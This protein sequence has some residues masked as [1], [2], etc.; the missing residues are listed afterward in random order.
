MKKIFL[1]ILFL[2]IVS[3]I[4]AAQTW[5]I[6]LDGGNKSQCSGLVDQPLSGA[7]GTDCRLSNPLFA[8]GTEGGDTGLM[9][10][11]DT[12]YIHSGAYKIG[13]GY[14]G[15]DGNCSNNAYSQDCKAR[16]IPS[17]PDVNHK[18][19][20]L[21]EGWD[22]EG[23]SRA[24]ELYGVEGAFHILSL[25]GS[26]NVE[27]QNLIITDHAQ[28]GRNHP[29]SA[30]FC[31]NS[32][33]YGN[34][35]Q[36]GIYAVDS[37]NVLLKNLIIRGLAGR[38]VMA[39]RIQ[40]WD[41][42]NVVISGNP[43]ID[44]EGDLGEP[45]A[46]ANKGTFNFS[47][48]QTR[49]AGCVDKYPLT[50]VR[51]VSES[52]L[53]PANDSCYGQDAGGGNGDGFSV[54]IG[55]PLDG[56][57]ATFNF[58]DS[59]FSDNMQDGLD[60]LH[61][62]VG[63]NFNLKRVKSVGNIGQQIKIAGNATA[64]DSII[65]GDC[66]HMAGQAFTLPSG[67]G[68]V[69]PCRAG[70]NAFSWDIVGVGNTLTL[71]GDT[72]SGEG[73]VLVVSSSLLN[74]TCNGLEKVIMRNTVLSGGLQYNGGGDYTDDYYSSGE[75]SGN[76]IGPCGSVPI[77]WSA[78]NAGN[79]VYNTKTGPCPATGISCADPLFT[80]L[81]TYDVSLKSGSPAIGL[82]N[83]AIGNPTDYFNITRVNSIGAVEFT[84][85]GTGGGGGT[86]SGGGGGNSGSVTGSLHGQLYGSFQ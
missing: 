81:A 36:N 63:Y 9:S 78:S 27:I 2:F 1:T 22:T 74:I 3:P 51:D 52:G 54:Y 16:P 33:P 17:G 4:W 62:E 70:G 13:F 43:N 67:D 85:G 44:W 59:N 72:I 82:L 84:T 30:L 39:G 65:I 20:I 14:G 24:P 35:A 55:G 41:V 26:D 73:D 60:G 31:N 21:G 69:V 48:F 32:P 29:H 79:L 47:H 37:E 34:W 25:D 75:S 57:G 46:W 68:D 40:D 53:I 11:G 10:G 66:S 15:T 6:G 23:L 80:N 49:Y 50:N 86:G 71:T 61:G 19:K 77:D 58:T 8:I 5:Y 7:S 38:G 56:Q 18:T 45:D 28:C 64:T 83:T 42:I 76:G 12:L